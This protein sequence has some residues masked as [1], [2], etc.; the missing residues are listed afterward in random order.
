MKAP[1]GEAC[2]A[3]GEDRMTEASNQPNEG[4]KERL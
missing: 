2:V 1:T 4:G 3:K